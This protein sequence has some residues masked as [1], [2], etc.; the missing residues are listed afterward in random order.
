VRCIGGG[1]YLI[2]AT[3]KLDNTPDSLKNRGNLAFHIIKVFE[4]Q[5]PVLPKAVSVDLDH[6]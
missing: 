1:F 5:D 4:K 3:Y 6:W 2:F